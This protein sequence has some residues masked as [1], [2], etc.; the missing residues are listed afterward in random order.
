MAKVCPDIKHNG[1]NQDDLV[2][3]LYMI[4]ASIH[5]IC[6]KLDADGTV[7]DTNYDVLCYQAGYDWVIVE[8]KN[9]SRIGHITDTLNAQIISPQGISDKALL[10]FMYGTY[11]ALYT[12]AL[13]LDNDGGVPLT[14]YVA[15]VWTAICSHRV[16]HDGNSW[17]GVGT[18][19]Y[20]HPGG[21]INQDRFVDWLYNIVYAIYI[22]TAQLDTDVLSD[23]NYAAL[24]YTASITLTVENSYGNKIGN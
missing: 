24:W 5:G 17:L 4:G 13:K 16:S 6:A 1:L 22:L 20:F 2:E 7:T 18:G 8:N 23:N 10:Q 9:G 11:Y 14:T 21:V 12:M 15:N 19:Y 3:L